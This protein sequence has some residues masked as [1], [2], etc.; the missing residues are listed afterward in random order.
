MA[1]K[2]D[3]YEKQVGG[4][5]REFLFNNE[6]KL[7][8]ELEDLDVLVD[9]E[10]NIITIEGIQFA[11]EENGNITKIE[12]IALSEKTKKLNIIQG[13]V[14]QPEAEL[15]ATLVAIQG[16]ISW[17]ISDEEVVKITGNGNK[18]T[19]TG[20][21]DGVAIITATCQGEEASCEVTV[22]TVEISTT[23]TLNST[24]IV[25]GKQET[26]EL[27]AEQNGTEEITW[28]S[29]DNRIAIVEGTGE[30]G[31]IGKVTGVEAGEVTIAARTQNQTATCKVT[32]AITA[33]SLLK[34]I[35]EI[36][37]G[38]TKKILVNGT[39]DQV[40]TDTTQYKKEIYDVNVV[41]ID[42]GLE[43]GTG[44]IVK[45]NGVEKAISEIQDL[46]V[47]SDGKTYSVGNTKDIG[48][49]SAYALNTVVLKVKGNLEI[50]NG[51]TLTSITG[52]YGGPKG[53]IVYCEEALTNHGTISMSQKGAKAQGQ[54]V[55]LS[56][57][58]S[59]LFSFVGSAGGSGGGSVSVSSDGKKSGI[60]GTRS[61]GFSCGG[62]RR[63][64][65]FYIFRWEMYFRQ[66]D[67][68]NK[69]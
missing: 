37:T 63:R 1:V 56:K 15:V 10:A 46:S 44:G 21:K 4:S 6:E 42:G 59:N 3:Y 28:E 24:N 61:A 48:T 67:S 31:K 18:V 54:N 64:S 60:G 29:S 38:G 50:Q 62:G 19:I 26:I 12:G 2:M 11:V 58:D 41:M 55:F 43:L 22:R 36:T 34:G 39:T 52:T 40:I 65:S 13:V 35:E 30:N 5:F 45:V 27:T 32:V 47:S 53:L 49:A 20:L 9:K 25:M 57:N 7:K 16:E 68:W 8:K 17:K 51:V 66:R 14:E 69:L 23:L 33:E